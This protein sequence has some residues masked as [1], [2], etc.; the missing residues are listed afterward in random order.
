MEAFPTRTLEHLVRIS[1]NDRGAKRLVKE[2]ARLSP[3]DD[4]EAY[5][6]KV[7]QKGRI[8]KE[9]MFVYPQD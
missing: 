5:L 6:L 1:A 4:L 3:G 2:I 7:R 9:V 8:H